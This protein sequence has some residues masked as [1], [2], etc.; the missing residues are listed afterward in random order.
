MKP[1][2][3]TALVVLGLLVTPPALFVAIYG[4]EGGGGHPPAICLVYLYAWFG[5]RFAAPVAGGLAL[6]AS[7]LAFSRA[8]TPWM[9][10]GSL[11]LGVFL[12]LASAV[13]WFHRLD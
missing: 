2:L 4:T 5:F 13:A 6:A 11:G 7:R 9:R 1:L 10:W 3:V 8:A 12:C